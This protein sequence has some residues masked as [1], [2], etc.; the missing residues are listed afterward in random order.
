MAIFTQHFHKDK[1]DLFDTRNILNGMVLLNI[2]IT[3]GNHMKKLLALLLTL[4]LLAGCLPMAFAAAEKLPMEL[5]DAVD[6]V[7]AYLTADLK[8][9][10]YSDWTILQ[11]ARSGNLTEQL[12]TDY[13]RDMAQKLQACNGVLDQKNNTT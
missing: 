9:G 3:G 12:R 5:S 1:T 6:G 10:S 4:A 13:L 11:L 7:S 2:S 8:T